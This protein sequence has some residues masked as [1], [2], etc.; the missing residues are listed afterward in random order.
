MTQ[1]SP[2]PF[3][4]EYSPFETQDGR[5]IPSFRI[6]DAEGDP[7]AETDSGKPLAQQEADAS[8]MAA[9][10]LLL[11]TLDAQTEV[12]QAVLDKWS[13]GDL[14]G[15]VRNLDEMVFVARAVITQARGGG[16]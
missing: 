15:A 9:A 3:M 5:E 13:R 14:A 8:L 4:I 11:E 1:H 7:V 16:A 6:F 2:T 12:A 10:S